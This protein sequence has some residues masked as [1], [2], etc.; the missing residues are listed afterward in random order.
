MIPLITLS[1]L[2]PTLIKHFHDLVCLPNGKNCFLYSPCKWLHWSTLNEESAQTWF[3]CRLKRTL[4][5]VKYWL[6][7]KSVP[8]QVLCVAFNLEPSPDHVMGNRAFLF[9]LNY[10]IH[11]TCIHFHVKRQL[12]T[13]FISLY[14][15]LILMIFWIEFSIETTM[16]FSPNIWSAVYTKTLWGCYVAEILL[17]KPQI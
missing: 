10:Q 11:M 12:V 13:V 1:F 5:F 16:I 9:P 8:I 14:R 2:E 17:I 15:L 6:S 4:C 7:S 3:S